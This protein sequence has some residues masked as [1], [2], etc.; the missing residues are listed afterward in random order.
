MLETLFDDVARELFLAELEEDGAEGID[1]GGLV[2]L[3]SVLEYVLHNVVPIGVL[4]ELGCM[5]GDFSEDGLGLVM[6][7]SCTWTGGD[8]SM[9]RWMT[10]QPYEWVH[11][12]RT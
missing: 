2:G 6:K 12:W 5:F 8:F 7:E 10:L 3:F 1:D 11:M 4:G 9:M